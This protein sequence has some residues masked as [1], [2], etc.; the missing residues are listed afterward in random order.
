MDHIEGT[1]IDE[2]SNM[3]EDET[4]KGNVEDGEDDETSVMDT[5]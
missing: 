3:G 4:A 5:L 1:G 2:N